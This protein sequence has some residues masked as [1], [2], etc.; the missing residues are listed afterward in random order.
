MATFYII[1]RTSGW[2]HIFNNGSKEVNISDFQAVLDGVNQTFIIQ[3]LNGANTP[4]TAVGILDIIVIDETDASIEETFANV[5]DLKVRLTAL[6][7]TPYLGAG[8][9]DAITGL[10]QEGTNVTITGSGTLADPYVISASGG[11]GAVDS[12]N[13]QTG[14]VV[15]GLT[16]ILTE[17][18]TATG[19]AIEMDATGSDDITTIT[20]ELVSVENSVSADSSIVTSTSVVSRDLTQQIGVF[21]D[22]IT[23]SKGA[24]NTDL[25]FTDPTA[26]RSIT[27]DDESGTVAMRSYVDNKVAG[28]LDLR[29]LWDASGNVFPTTGGSGTA[30]AILKGDFWYVSVA[31]VLNGVAVN[32]GDSFF[33]NVDSPT[34][35]DWL[36]LEANLGY[37]P[38]NVANKENTTL[39]TSTTKYPTNRLTKEYADAKV[40]DAITD[41]VT[42]IAPSQNAVFDAL[43]N[44][45]LNPNFYIGTRW[46][47]QYGSAAFQMVGINTAFTYSN[48][49]QVTVAN[50][51][52]LTVLPALNL[53]STAVAGTLAYYR[54]SLNATIITTRFVH[55]GHIAMV[56]NV[57]DAR[58]FYGLS[59]AS[60]ANP[61]NVEPDTIANILGLCKLS[62]SNNFHVIHNDGS[63]TATTIDLGA[64]FPTTTTDA[65]IYFKLTCNGSTVTYLVNRLDADGNITHT[66]S[67]TLS[68]NLPASATLLYHRFWITNNA[69][70]SIFSCNVLSGSLG[71]Y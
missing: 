61:T 66:A 29:G 2:W 19:L 26:N 10:I 18:G 53:A 55:E 3:N 25:T 9:A 31:G 30:G 36:I 4:Q 7:Y 21:K 33:A 60:V 46:Q 43:A 45:L 59:S 56:T 22:K 8:N 40:A 68:T 65:S 71:R 49:N 47:G 24:F 38:E 16:E 20:N 64:N 13:G 54:Q 39:D 12:V 5:E 51:N 50:T 67:G 15:L 34:S 62:T 37:V 70:A 57:T 58:L 1:K 63:G 52:G 28:L 14:D 32:I 11:G 27:F 6:G 69:T 48:A 41:G 44:R 35:S 42:T 23:R 17:S